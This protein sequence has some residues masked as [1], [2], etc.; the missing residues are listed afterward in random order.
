MQQ[1]ASRYG[2]MDWRDLEERRLSVWHARSGLVLEAA[3]ATTRRRFVISLD[4]ASCV[5]FKSRI[6]RVKMGLMVQWG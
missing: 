6:R 4:S 2:Q 1:D 3:C 5:S